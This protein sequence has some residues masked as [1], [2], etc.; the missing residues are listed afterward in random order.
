MPQMKAH[1]DR[2]VACWNGGDLD[3]YL[4]LY[5]DSIRLHGYTPEPMDKP[6]VRE[7]YRMV[8]AALP[9]AGKPNPDLVIHETLESG[10][11]LSCRFVMSGV[12]SGAFMNVPASGKPYAL[13]GITILRF[14]GDKAVER[15]SCAD[16]LG[17][18]VQVGAPP[19]P[20]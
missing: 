8:C 19:P 5:D 1:L 9:A 16:M 11:L 12:H 4:T 7:F 3:G 6:A 15:W 17:F 20:G 10:D 18:L 14:A 13:P 2:A